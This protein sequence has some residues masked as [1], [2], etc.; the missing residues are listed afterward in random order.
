LAN[1]RTSSESQS[2]W[3]CTMARLR[4]VINDMA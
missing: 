1:A 4:I 2:L 3:A